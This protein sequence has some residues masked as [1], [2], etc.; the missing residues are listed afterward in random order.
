MERTE[1]RA[2]V[3]VVTRNRAK[4][5]GNLL[6]S[7]TSQTLPASEFEVVV[8]DDGSSDHTPA[9]LA[10]ARETAPFELQVVRIDDRPGLGAVRNRGWR[11][12]RGGLV[13]FIDDDCEA[14]PP[15]LMSLLE[16][17]DGPGTAVQGRTTPIE[18]ELYRN[19]PLSRTKL[20]E[21]AG[22]W[23]QTC[24]IA[25]PRP[26][27]ERL[28]GFDESF[29][30]PEPSASPYRGPVIRTGEDTDL[31]WRAIEAGARIV[32]A[33]E[34]RVRHAV[35]EIGVRGWLGVARRER[36]LSPLFRLHPG[37]RAEVARFGLFKNDHHALIALAG[38]AV[39]VGRRHR[40]ALLLCLPYLRLLAAR[41]RA[42]GVGPQWALWYTLFDSI[43]LASSVRG[44][45][46][47][48]SP[49]V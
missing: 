27:L 19:G 42:Q 34:A 16:A 35:E 46:E 23:Y 47:S 21:T 26:L 22:P 4:R 45:V 48:R 9:L 10:A 5:L 12:G 7:L 14:D 17:S 32:Y 39:L 28:D 8:V 13:C 40:A 38:A 20:I 31:G 1:P 15:W 41:C 43:A 49:L 30:V 37:L 44:A 6:R 24:N 29:G 3:V 36:S 33:P 2:S 18:R 11:A 25:Y